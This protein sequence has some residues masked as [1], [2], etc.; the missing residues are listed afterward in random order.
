[1]QCLGASGSSLS[2]YP[3]IPQAAGIAARQPQTLDGR[4]LDEPAFVRGSGDG[5]Q[6]DGCASWSYRFLR[7][8][9]PFLRHLTFTSASDWLLEVES[10]PAIISYSLREPVSRQ[11]M[12]SWDD[13]H[14]SGGLLTYF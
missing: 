12:D 4:Q 5:D 7:R 9:W 1:M 3:F 14:Y 13:I 8:G 2:N 10:V 6:G 11:S